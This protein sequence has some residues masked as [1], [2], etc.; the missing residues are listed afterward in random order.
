[1]SHCNTPC[2]S[3]LAYIG[4]R[5]QANEQERQRLQ[6]KYR[7]LEDEVRTCDA[8]SS[9]RQNLKRHWNRLEPES[10][11]TPQ[12]Y[13]KTPT[14]A[15]MQGE[16]YEVKLMALWFLRALETG[17][18][19]DIASNMEVAGS[20]DD[21]V[22]RLGRQTAFLQLKHKKNVGTIQVSQLTNL[23]GNF[24]VLQHYKSYCR[25]RQQWGQHGDLPGDREF[26]DALFILYTNA[27]MRT[28]V[29]GAAVNNNCD[30]LNVLTSGGSCYRF[31]EG[32][33]QEV[34]DFFQSLSKYLELLKAVGV[35]ELPL[36]QKMLDVVEGLYG[37]KVKS[38][39]HVREALK[40][41]ETAGDV[42]GI[43]EFLSQLRLFTGQASQHQLDDIIKDELK[44]VD[45]DK[46]L[47][48]V[49]DWWQNNRHFL[50]RT[51]PFW[52][53]LCADHISESLLKQLQR[54]EV[55]FQET[56][57]QELGS[58]ILSLKG[59]VYI[60][61]QGTVELS[62]LKL[63]KSLGAEPHLLVRY[64]ELAARWHDV[65]ALWGSWC[66]V[67]VVVLDA[68]N[69]P[70][71]PADPHLT[72]VCISNSD[73]GGQFPTLT[74]NTC[75]S[76]L[77]DGSQRLVLEKPVSFQGCRIAAKAVVGTDKQAVSADAV[78]QLLTCEPVMGAAVTVDFYI[79]RTLQVCNKVRT[80][81]ASDRAVGCSV[82][83]AMSASGLRGCRTRE[84]ISLI[85]TEEDF[86]NLTERY[87]SVHWLYMDNGELTWKKSHGDMTIL[88]KHLNKTSEYKNVME[89]SQ[90]VV[91]VSADP[92]MGKS[93]LLSHLAREIKQA[94]PSMF[95]ILVSLGDSTRLLRDLPGQPS[96]EHVINFLLCV[97]DIPETWEPLFR[98]KLL[99]MQ[100]V[101][102]LFDDYDEISP[103]YSHKVNLILKQLVATG[104]Q[105]LWVTTKPTLKEELE[106]ELS[107]L[108]LT[109]EPFSSSDQKHFLS[110][111]WKQ[112]IPS[113]Q[114]SLEDNFSR[115]LLHLMKGNFR[116]FLGIPLQCAFLCEAFQSD[117][118]ISIEKGESCLPDVLNLFKFC[119]KFIDAKL[120]N[121]Y[122]RN[123]MDTTKPAVQE[124]CNL[125]KANVERNYSITAAFLLL[126]P[127]VAEIPALKESKDEYDEFVR[128]LK[129]CSENV[130]IVKCTGSK[131]E[132]ILNTI[133]EYFLALWL[134]RN[135]KQDYVSRLLKVFLC[136][137][138]DDANDLTRAVYSSGAGDAVREE[139]LNLNFRNVR[140]FFTHFLVKDLELHSAVLDL[141]VPAVL[142]LL[143]A[144][145][146]DV[147]AR[148]SGG[149]TVL[150]AAVLRQVDLSGGDS[151][152]L[153]ED[154]IRALIVCGADPG[155]QDDVFHW[156][157][158]HLADS[159]KAW[160]AVV[161]LFEAQPFVEDLVN[162]KSKIRE[163][164]DSV[165]QALLSVALR[166]GCVHLIRFLLECGLNI[167]HPVVFENSFK[168]YE[169]TM[170]LE[171]TRHGHLN[172]VKL[173]VDE[174]CNIEHRDSLYKRTALMCAV[175]HSHRDILE[176]LLQKGANIM[177]RD[178]DGKT[179]MDIARNENNV[180]ALTLLLPQSTFEMLHIGRRRVDSLSS[181]NF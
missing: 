8:G 78:I 63:H 112:C 4:A 107:T 23:K 87:S 149:Q 96:L 100:N 79:P 174:G 37:S 101:C 172:L 169:S 2:E 55:N 72:L 165:I 134:A 144:N 30:V 36:D 47:Q 181:L 102:V 77:D 58:K 81:I 167:E 95:V 62:I 177:I 33:L 44:G 59:L 145:K 68:T 171:A 48:C 69:P 41:L 84:G 114:E 75:L 138:D 117:L 92:G 13:K 83:L 175:Q 38:P 142:E 115:K 166:K 64:S 6:D 136:D 45:Y 43:L 152:Q 12:K 66:R 170:L 176:F 153:A 76:D 168:V 158:L 146:L 97:A 173:L 9:P 1:M 67:L 161:F 86:N 88:R 180:E 124:V 119:T 98:C 28:D 130:G 73:C 40:E 110:F 19:F 46:F 104:L 21:V 143:S 126:Q 147:R 20:F 162:V 155:I 49:E 25:V 99:N 10:S 50:T 111:K 109:L 141:E 163:G 15:D 7:Q 154:L 26:K 106:K 34:S 17:H 39:T 128:K 11:A 5:L 139:L 16:K 131:L 164:D 71:L 35:E 18:N 105:K 108:A 118:R 179:A 57:L 24:S 56:V 82:V 80:Q 103:I 129:D 120:L 51:E 160:T 137:A 123:K 122:E 31:S 61:T 159:V 133:K 132:F 125:K 151:N 157:P 127:D 150:H 178:A 85:N 74:D 121:Y 140:H 113:L 27:K 22:L 42:S 148:D 53:Q 60:V 65:Q 116:K 135:F 156:R 70:D 91:V 32:P 89:V 3:H 94:D 54:V 93:T 52:Q 90:R 14:R 29:V